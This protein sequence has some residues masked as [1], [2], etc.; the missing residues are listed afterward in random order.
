MIVA[1]FDCFSGASGDMLLGALVDAGWPAAELV[2]LPARLGLSGVSVSVG[3]ARRGAIEAAKVTVEVAGAQPHRH[4]HQVRERVQAADVPAR[5]KERAL[6][7]FERLAEAEAKVHGTTVDQI[8]FHEVGAADALIDFVGTCWGLERL[9]VEEVYASPLP[10]GRGSVR[11]EHGLLP[12]PAPAT[13]ELLRGVPV[14]MPDVQAEL[15]TPTGAALLTTLVQRWGGAP[16]F[17]VRAQGVGAG[18]RDLAEQPNVLR[19]FL[20]ETEGVAGPANAG[21]GDESPGRRSVIVLE[22]ALDDAS[23]QWVAPLVPR[24]LAAGARD[25]FLTPIQMKK[26][27]PGILVT[28]LCDP[29]REDELAGILFRESPTLGVRLR[30]EERIEL[31]R[32]AVEVETPHGRVAA[33]EAVLPDGTRRLMPEYESL[34]ALSEKTGIPLLELSRSVFAA[35]NGGH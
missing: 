6:R 32:R 7:A 12:V 26:G 23:P 11:T 17:R 1:Y 3:R 34:A 31:A 20:G 18:G 24:L 16:S 28:C 10:L 8:H 4:L 19:V 21:A 25:A 35:W 5:A 13:A 33:K 22:T 14:E 30:R 15:V 29:G 27:R 9:G 2:S